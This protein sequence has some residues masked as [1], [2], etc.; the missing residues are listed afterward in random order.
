MPAFAELTPDSE[1][2]IH[3]WI[4]GPHWQVNYFADDQWNEPTKYQE[5][6]LVKSFC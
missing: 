2:A 1:V 4:F 6:S 5:F 3:L